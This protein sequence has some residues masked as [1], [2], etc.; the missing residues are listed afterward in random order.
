MSPNALVPQSSLASYLHPGP[1]GFITVD[2]DRFKDDTSYQEL[3]D[4]APEGNS[5]ATG[6][7]TGG[8]DESTVGS[9][10][11]FNAQKEFIDKHFRFNVG[12]RFVQ[13]D[14]KIVGPVTIA[15][16]RQEQTL[17]S[18]YSEFLPSFN[19]AA[20]LTDDIVLRVSSSRTMTRAN[21]RDMLPNATFSDPSAQ[22][23]TLGNPDLE[24]FLSTNVDLG[25]EWY[26]GDE[27]YIGLTLFQKQITGLHDR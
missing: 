5:A 20:N 7:G 3:S 26:T 9:Y 12:G 10:I 16:V 15:G 17:V 6:A 22:A 18:D 24:P 21:P 8:V 23:V 19:V 14:Q 13:T 11:D 1:A 25:G 27:G 2:F 4:N